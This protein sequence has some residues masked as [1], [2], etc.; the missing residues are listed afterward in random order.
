LSKK[1][2]I[3]FIVITVGILIALVAFSG[4]SSI[5]VSKVDVNTV[6]KANSQNGNIADH[7]FGNVNSKVTLIEYGDFQC[8]P[9]GAI[10]PIVKSITNQYTNQ[11]QFV[12]RNFPIADLHQNA[13]AAAA[14]A[15][16]AGLQGKYWQMHD[17][18]YTAQSDWSELS[19]N[20]RTKFFDNL[21][22]QLDLNLKKFDS[23]MSSTQ[24]SN[25]ISYDIALGTKAGVDGTPTFF[26]NGKKLDGKTDFSSESNFKN[27]INT[28]LKK[29][30]ILPPQ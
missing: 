12:F 8:Q 23:D 28:A 7:V 24:V 5:D 29:A 13:K 4:G 19:I 17:Q 26:L 20:D 14:S 22:K 10:Y 18:L 2:W 30:G 9:C 1:S 21:A 11:L 15:E 27:T 25:K 3:I 6:Q 16:A